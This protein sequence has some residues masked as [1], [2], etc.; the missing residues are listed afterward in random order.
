MGQMGHR[1]LVQVPLLLLQLPRQA[2][3]D[4]G[5]VA[6][7]T[8][9]S[10]QA[11]MIEPWLQPLSPRSRGDHSASTSRRSKVGADGTAL[12]IAAPVV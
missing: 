8:T 2:P 11:V 6:G 9:R 4:L 3:H 1:V 12:E 5:A 10:D 7:D